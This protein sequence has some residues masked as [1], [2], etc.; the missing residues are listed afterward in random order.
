[1][2]MAAHKAPSIG[3]TPHTS[4]ATTDALKLIKQMRIVIEQD[5]IVLIVPPK[6]RDRNARA[7]CAITAHTR[8]ED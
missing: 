2:P 4:A 7:H 6:N 5:N 1:M 3:E 8:P